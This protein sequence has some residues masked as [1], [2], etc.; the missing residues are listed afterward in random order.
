V[1]VD[2]MIPAYGDGPLVRETVTSVLRQDDPHWRLRVVDDGVGL[3]EWLRGLGDERVS[4]HA[5]PVRLGIN[6]NF[7]RCVDLSSAELVVLLGADDRLLPDFV[8]RVRRVA[9]R[10]PDAAFVHTG[11]RIIDGA[12]RPIMPLVDRVKRA[13]SIRATGTGGEASLAVGG[14]R[15]AASLLRGNWMYFPSVVFRR[16]WLVRHGFR[17]GYDIVLDLD[18]YLRILRSGGQAVLLARPGI[19]YRRHPDSLSSSGAEDG[20]RFVEERGYFAEV[21]AELA[22]EGWT[23]AAR[24]AHWHLTSRLHAVRKLA[25]LLATGNRRAARALL[26]GALG[27]A[28]AGAD[29][30]ESEGARFR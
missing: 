28:P 2:V 27:T 5:N 18:L 16:D 24:A 7:Q 13:T 25:G 4:Y 9:R 30:R 17:P 3:G 19:E 1:L 8:G 26:H 21:A 20:S 29:P 11:A 22:A 14:E 12:G 10:H 15:L 23:R 6:R